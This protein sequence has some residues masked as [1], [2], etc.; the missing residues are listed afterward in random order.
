MKLNIVPARTGFLWVKLGARTFFRQPLGMAGLFFMFMATVSVL[1]IVPF[2]GT[3]VALALVPAATLG[4]MAATREAEQGRFPMPSTLVSAFRGGP[5]KTRSMLILGAMYAAGL[6]LVLGVSALFAT[7]VPPVD[8]PGG[9][10]TPE[11]M[12]E[13]LSSQ[14]LWVALILYVPLLMAFWHAPALVYWHGVTPFKSL[15]FSVMACW[16][17]K[18]AMLLYT[19]G[20]MVV[21]MIAGVLMNLL[22]ALLGGTALLNLLIYPMVLLLAAMFHTSIWFTVR[23]SFVTEDKPGV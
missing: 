7:D 5:S 4:L 22:A 14:G 20:W 11:R 13:M 3:L 9:E 16:A 23:D 1:S 2:V 8:M 19:L 6:M 17:N 12:R 18:G 21:I 10:V 15:F